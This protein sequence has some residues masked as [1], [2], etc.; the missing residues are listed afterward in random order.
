MAAIMITSCEKEE[1]GNMENNQNMTSDKTY[2]DGPSEELPADYFDQI[3]GFTSNLLAEKPLPNMEVNQAILY[4]ES[5][6]DFLLVNRKAAISN[7]IV[8]DPIKGTY[9]FKS[10]GESGTMSGNDIKAFYGQIKQEVI[11]HISSLEV[12][13]PKVQIAI[14]LVDLKYFISGN[15]INFSVEPTYAINQTTT[16]KT[17]PTSCS[18]PFDED[19]QL[20]G[21]N[22]CGGSGTGVSGYNGANYI[23]YYTRNLCGTWNNIISCYGGDYFRNDIQSSFYQMPNHITTCFSSLAIGLN[24]DCLPSDS[25]EIYYSR[26][27]EQWNGG[28]GCPNTFRGNRKLFD[29]NTIAQGLNPFASRYIAKYNYGNCLYVCRDKDCPPIPEALSPDCYGIWGEIVPCFF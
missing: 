10:I 22:Y 2:R 9:T 14:N 4:T 20:N 3:Q 23:D 26:I 24:T 11:D 29:V 6:L 19:L 7:R 8:S 12:D 5:T 13:D 27:K 15:V 17:L 16:N 25:L 1:F 21:G 18:R 28:P